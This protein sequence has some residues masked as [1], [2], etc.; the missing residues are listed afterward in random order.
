MAVH[1]W[2]NLS[3]FH[4]LTA[5]RQLGVDWLDCDASVGLDVGFAANAKLPRLMANFPNTG[6][7]LGMM[8][9]PIRVDFD[10]VEDR[11]DQK[12]RPKGGPPFGDVR[13]PSKV[14]L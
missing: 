14:T 6:S 8:P 11:Y 10:A 9:N 12:T 13:Q 5:A 3:D 2:W 7:V 4:V 1:T